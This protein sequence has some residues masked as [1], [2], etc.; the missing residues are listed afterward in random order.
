MVLVE[1]DG[2]FAPH[3]P[4]D[5]FEDVVGGF[6][7]PY[8]RPTEEHLAI[9]IKGSWCD[10]HVSV[11]WAPDLEA[12]HM[13]A[14]LDVK[15]PEAKRG[16]VHTLLA[17]INEQLWFGHFDLWSEESALMFRLALPLGGVG[18]ATPEQCETLLQVVVEACERYY[19][20]FQFVLWAGKTAQEAIDASMF[21][22]V[23]TA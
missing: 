15:V 9:T 19:P 10:Y 13:S 2:F 21:D 11:T 7:W 17:F 12:I 4:V 23:G 22:T 3:N 1:S 16:E 6:D 8:E 20:A 5:T 14:T 18:D